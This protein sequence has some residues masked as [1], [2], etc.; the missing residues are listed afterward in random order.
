[1]LSGYVIILL[2]FLFALAFP[3]W[4][5]R[6]FWPHVPL[7][8]VAAFFA[9]V[10]PLFVYF[11]SAF[12]VPEWKGACRHGWVDC[13]IVG[14]TAFF[15]F[16]LFATAAL[17]RLDVLR[18]PEPNKTW[19]VMGIYLGAIVATTCAVFGVVCIAWQGWML[20]P[21]YVAI[22]YFI[23]AVQLMR[24]S[25]ISAGK[26]FWATM[27]TL[28]SWLTSWQWSR[29]VYESLPNQAPQG[30]FVV[31]AAGR[32][33]AQIV[34]PFFEIN[35]RGENRRANQQL[36]TLWQFEERWR[37]QFPQ[38]HRRFRQIYNRLGPC[39]AAGIRSPWLADAMF[40]ALKPAEWLAKLCLNKKPSNRL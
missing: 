7:A 21:A 26:Y 15:P 20:V 2:L 3:A 39:V 19:V 17:Y 27:F 31:T 30:C 40:L 23:R 10:L 14:K 35:H 25:K 13:F 9:V 5:G 32:G 4:I 18:E 34:G 28:P 24:K 22:W 37:K 12:M 8:M 16:V 11:F 1:M 6:S 38:S 29:Q 36:I 33:H